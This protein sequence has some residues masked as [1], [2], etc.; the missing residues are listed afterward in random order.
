MSND[1]SFTHFNHPSIQ[2]PFGLQTIC[3]CGRISYYRCVLCN[4][5]FTGNGNI[6]VAV[7]LEGKFNSVYQNRVLPFA[8]KD[9]INLS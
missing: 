1:T 6:P 8:E 3:I 7:L 9:F 5:D 4:L 2:D